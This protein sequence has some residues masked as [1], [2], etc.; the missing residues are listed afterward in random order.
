MKSWTLIVSYLWKDTWSRWL[1]QPSSVLS[2]IFV[3]SLLVTVATVILVAFNLLERNLRARL[4]NF[5]INTI[6]SRD[7]LASTDPEVLP[8]QLRPDRLAPLQQYGDEIRLR[9]YYM[10][11]QT[12]WARDVMVMSY[13]EQALPFLADLLNTNTSLVYFTETLPENSLVEVS[14]QRQND[15][16]VVRR[17]EGIWRPL[18]SQQ[19]LL[20][21]QGWA[22]EAER[23][24]Y[25]D[26]TLFKRRD[27][28]I[29]IS[30]FVS[31]IQNVY[32]MDYRT[33]PQIQ[34]A[35]NMVKD[36][37]TLQERQ[38]QW[39][40]AMAGLLGLA[41]AL[42]FGAIA[43][44]EFRQNAYVSALLR[45][46]GAP[47]KAL[48]LRQWLEN[49]FLANLAALS[50]ILLLACFHAELFKMLGFPR[51]L[52]NLNKVNPYLSWEIGLVLLWVNVGALLSSI[53]VAIGLRKPVGEILS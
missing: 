13:N 10:R 8:N 30:E 11:A 19:L 45:S 16:A 40:A 46:F 51:D 34:S 41:V 17:A 53:S 50:A 47:G 48:Y 15:I 29:S 22:P 4:E 20:V 21:P 39:R 38:T 35:A 3:G 24:G 5:G 6:V 33:P 32:S 28:H 49:A 14:Y 37:E 43:V 12:P 31:A 44:L 7:M 42:V 2:R 36:L 27:E 26:T 1:E 9:Q 23:L 25:V 52:L 18:V